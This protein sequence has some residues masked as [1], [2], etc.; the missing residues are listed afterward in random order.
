[1]PQVC[2]CMW[3]HVHV[4]IK[5]ALNIHALVLLATW[6]QIILHVGMCMAIASSLM[7]VHVYWMCMYIIQ[8]LTLVEGIRRDIFSLGWILTE[9]SETENI[10]CIFLQHKSL[11]VLLSPVSQKKANQFKKWHFITSGDNKYCMCMFTDLHVHLYP[12]FSPIKIL[13]TIWPK[14]IQIRCP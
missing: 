7:H 1:M 10:N 13:S 6:G 3:V 9:H 14:M 5:H 12:I 4:Q 11:F 8:I 2:M